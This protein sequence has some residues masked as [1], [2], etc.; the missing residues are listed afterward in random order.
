M[1]HR[2]LRLLLCLCL[3][4][5]T[6]V[7]A[8]ASVGMAMAGSMAS[9][10]AAPAGAHAPCH[11]MD[12]HA[13]PHAAAHAGHAAHP[14]PDCCALGS[15]E[16]LQHASLALLSLPMVPATPQGRPLLPRPLTAGRSSPP[17]EQP[18]RPPIA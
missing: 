13:S 10:H 17:P 12:A 18:V 3:I 11:H 8:W 16:C 6:A 2:L 9:A 1:S 15:C 7:G 14:A 4:A 5:N